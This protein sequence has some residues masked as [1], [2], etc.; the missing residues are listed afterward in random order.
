MTDFET[1]VGRLDAGLKDTERWIKCPDC[2]SR[3]LFKTVPGT[4][5][6]SGP[7]F[8]LRCGHESDDAAFVAK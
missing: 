2:T 8:C 6:A 1:L 7:F 5:G 4:S 3:T